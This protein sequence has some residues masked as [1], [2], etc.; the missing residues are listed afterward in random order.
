MMTAIKR[1]SKSVTLGCAVMAI[2][3]L[4][5]YTTAQEPTTFSTLDGG[6]VSLASL[7]GNV[8]V[9]IFGG[10][11]DP[12]CRDEFRALQ[13]LVERYRGKDVSIFW[14]SIDPTGVSNE[15]LRAPCGPAGDV[16]IV[17]DPGR[18]AFKRFGGR[19]LPTVAVLNTSGE[20]HGAPRGGF[21]PDS[22]FVNEIANLIDFLLARQ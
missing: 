10:T 19:Q 6:T 21:N 3:A 5:A 15:Q 12:Q 9:L 2:L 1:A 11:Q 22:D 20:V 13:S 17:R 8:V 14:V 16:T 7:R 18:A 4:S